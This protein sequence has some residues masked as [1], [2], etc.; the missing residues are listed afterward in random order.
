MRDTTAVLAATQRPRVVIASACVA[1]RV[2]EDRLGEPLGLVSAFFLHGARFV[3]A[4]LQP[5]PDLQAPLVMGL[6]RRAWRESG[7][8]RRAWHAAI[9][10]ICDWTMAF[11]G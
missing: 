11:G 4:P 10:R 7:N 5:I 9:R 1:G 6:F 3:L 8:P 2:T